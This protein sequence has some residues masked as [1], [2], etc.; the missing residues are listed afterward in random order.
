MSKVL[1]HE[2]KIIL[3]HATCVRTRR[4][5][6]YQITVQI[7]VISHFYF[8]R[9]HIVSSKRTIFDFGVRIS[10][11]FYK[12]NKFDLKS[13]DRNLFYFSDSNNPIE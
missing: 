5:S 2:M 12:N 1:F 10:I 3:N 7:A 6:S 9:F 8:I 11:K 4:L 13:N